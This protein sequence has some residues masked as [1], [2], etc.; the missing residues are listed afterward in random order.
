MKQP[1]FKRFS[2]TT[3]NFICDVCKTKVL[4]NGYTDH[5][6]NCLWCK[7]VDINPGDR[8]SKCLGLMK[9]LGTEHNRAGFYIKYECEKCAMKKRIHAAG[10]D[11]QE[12]L[13]KLLNA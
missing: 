2:R 11:N 3:E 10:N 9:P 5:C 4:G 8:A 6:P 13:F 12:M 7:H 1:K